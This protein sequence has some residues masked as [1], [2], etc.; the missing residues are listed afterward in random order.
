M[1]WLKDICNDFESLLVRSNR[2]KNGTFDI[3]LPLTCRNRRTRPGVDIGTSCQSC[4]KTYRRCKRSW[5]IHYSHDHRKISTMEAVFAGP[6]RLLHPRP[7][8]NTPLASTACTQ[9]FIDIFWTRTVI[10]QPR[11]MGTKFYFFW[12]S[13]YGEEKNYEFRS[14]QPGIL[15]VSVSF[16]RACESLY[17]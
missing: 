8:L 9:R 14:T 1:G 5:A 2:G 12:A 4:T 11:V 3:F 17:A 16:I 6:P 13:A 10:N 15:I 7:S